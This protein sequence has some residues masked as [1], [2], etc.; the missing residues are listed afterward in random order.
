MNYKIGI[1]GC[2][3]WGQN[4]VRVFRDILNSENVKI[5]DTSKEKLK[6]ILHQYPHVDTFTDYNELLKNKEISGVVVSTPT[7]DHYSIARKAL[8]NGKHVLVE[9]PLTTDVAS[10]KELIGVARSKKKILMVG[11]TFIYNSAV[12]KMK[13]YINRG[14]IGR[15]YYLHSTRTHLGLIRKDVNVIWDLVPH[16]VSIFS[17]LLGKNPLW[18]SA[19]GGQFLHKGKEDIGFITLAYPN[20]ILGNIHVSWIDSNKVREVVIVGSK[21]RIIFDDINN[22][23]KLRVYE[24][25]VSVEKPIDGFGEWQYLLRDGDIISPKIEMSEPLRVQCQHFIDCIKN[26]KTCMTDGSSGLNVVKT[27]VA[28]EKSIRN[29]G[30]AI[31][32]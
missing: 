10:A 23:E 11:H 17:Y 24:K 5:C 21:K 20:G 19:V 15:I 31:K 25:G 8:I 3:Y 7:V 30:K 9:K 26:S 16:D 29:N 14:E 18:V 22:L 6:K 32:V 1:I 13:E 2:G 12:R 27:I 4:Y 28:I